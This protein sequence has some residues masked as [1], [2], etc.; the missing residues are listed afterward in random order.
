MQVMKLAVIIPKRHQTF[1]RC[2]DYLLKQ[3]ERKAFQS[4]LKHLVFSKSWREV[5]K[6]EIQ[7]WNTLIQEEFPGR[8]LVSTT[9]MKNPKTGKSNE[10]LFQIHPKVE[11]LS[12]TTHFLAI[13]K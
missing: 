10:M 6:P 13:I 2:M 9:P 3:P 1:A 4:E 7:L 5:V 11:V 8:C 12:R